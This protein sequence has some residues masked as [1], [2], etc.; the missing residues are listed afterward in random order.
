MNR[1]FLVLI[2]VFPLAV[3]TDL[4]IRFSKVVVD[5]RYNTSAIDLPLTSEHYPI[6]IETF[7]WLRY[8]F[9][10]TV[11][12]PQVCTECFWDFDDLIEVSGGYPSHPSTDETNPF[13][14]EL[15]HVVEIQ[16]LRRRNVDPKTIMPLP[17]AWADYTI[18]QVAE[19][20]HDEFLGIF[21]IGLISTWDKAKTIKIDHVVIPFVTVVDFIRANCMLADLV[22]WA[23]A[24]VGPSNFALKWHV[25][26]V[27]PEE[28]AFKIATGEIT[29][30]PP[31]SL[32]E[33]I[34]SMNL[35]VP[36]NLTAYPEGSPKHPSWPA[37]HSASSAASLWMPVVMVLTPEQYCQVQLTDY[38][39]AYART[40]AGVHY[41]SDNLAGLKL[42]QEI[43]ARVL[44][45][46]LNEKYGS[47]IAR[48]KAKI[49][50]LRFNWDNFLDTDCAK[51]LV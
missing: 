3:A 6:Q 4:G 42:G 33:S 51:G 10:S 44:P 19:A 28:I 39:I 15:A 45:G 36:T 31:A 35:S 50:T 27:R 2:A 20:V 40:V 14:T 17:D 13:W 29:Q 1:Y 12:I 38:A 47:S 5:P 7:R 21:H 25:G 16:Q 18:G 32:V 34:K 22:T 41:Q 26:M 11:T 9:A 48:V 43:V 49:A 30:G 23:V 24:R 46:Y 8:V 37:M